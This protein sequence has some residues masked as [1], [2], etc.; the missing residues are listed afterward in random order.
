MGWV[1]IST[2]A[3]KEVGLFPLDM[4]RSDVEKAAHDEDN[5]V[6]GKKIMMVKDIT[7]IMMIMMNKY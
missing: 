7:I 6:E 2:E 4:E 3:K 5:E 1:L